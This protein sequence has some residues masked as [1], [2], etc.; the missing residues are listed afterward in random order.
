[1]RISKKSQHRQP[2]RKERAMDRFPDDVFHSI[3]V[4]NDLNDDH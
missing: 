2:D 4:M 1:M 3:M